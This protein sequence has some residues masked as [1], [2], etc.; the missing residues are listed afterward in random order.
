MRLNACIVSISCGP[1]MKA[2]ALPLKGLL[3]VELDVFADERGFFVECYHEEKFR[4]L[5][6]PTR[7]TQENWSHSGPGVLRGLHYQFRPPQGKL[8]GVVRGRV[9]DVAVDIRPA[10]ATFGQSYGMELSGASGRL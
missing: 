6:L 10:S 2:L 7:F 4:A 5:G 3:L 1:T 8:V 9:W